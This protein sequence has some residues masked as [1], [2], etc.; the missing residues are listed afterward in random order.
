M[1]KY[2]KQKTGKNRIISVKNSCKKYQNN[3]TYFQNLQESRNC[4]G[5]GRKMRKKRRL[6]KSQNKEKVLRIW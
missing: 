6:W 5:L 4:A 3:V 2:A 1:S